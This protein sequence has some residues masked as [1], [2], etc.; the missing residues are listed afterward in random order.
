[1]TERRKLQSR[2]F[3]KFRL[4]PLNLIQALP[5]DRVMVCRKYKQEI[6]RERRLYGETIGRLS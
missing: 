3:L 1:M 4:P 6:L 5:A 2:R